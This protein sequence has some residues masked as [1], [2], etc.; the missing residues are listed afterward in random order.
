[1]RITK[2]IALKSDSMARVADVLRENLFTLQ[3]YS[4]LYSDDNGQPAMVITYT[5]EDDDIVFDVWM[6]NG[7]MQILLDNSRLVR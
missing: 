5:I 2:R 4:W 1:M 6:I 3:E 7:E